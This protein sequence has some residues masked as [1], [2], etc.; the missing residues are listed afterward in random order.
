MNLA[1]YNN[2][3]LIFFGNEGCCVIDGVGY[4]EVAVVYAEGE[5]AEKYNNLLREL[6][7]T[8]DSSFKSKMNYLLDK[9]EFDSCKKRGG[10]FDVLFIGEDLY[11]SI[12]IDF[13]FYD[14]LICVGD[15]MFK[16]GNGA[17]AIELVSIGNC[18]FKQL[19][20]FLG[21]KADGQLLY[22]LITKSNYEANPY[23]KRAD[24]LLGL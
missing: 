20:S 5:S 1:I 10:H 14:R 4:R 6:M 21:F 9:I 18:D 24:A 19:Q 8:T 22:N 7:M 2:T 11:N 16:Q 17:K 12:E 23:K 3:K 13:S 15:E